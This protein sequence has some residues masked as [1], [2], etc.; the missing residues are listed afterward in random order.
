MNQVLICTVEQSPC[1]AEFQ[2]WIAVDQAFQPADLGINAG[3]IAEVFGW[4]FAA[5]LML[6]FLGYGIG[7][8]LKVI[9][10]V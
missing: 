4:G 6:F 10:M 2:Q 9:R 3:S 8:G 1:P 5:V 7:A